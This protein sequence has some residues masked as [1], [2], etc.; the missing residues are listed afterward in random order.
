MQASSMQTH[1]LNPVNT[2]TE[3]AQKVSELWASYM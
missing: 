2:D 1:S 3:G